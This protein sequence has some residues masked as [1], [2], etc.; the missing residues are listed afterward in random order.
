[1]WREP[2]LAI[3]QDFAGRTPGALVEVKSVALAW[4]YRMVD[5]EAGPRRANELQ[6]HL[7]QLLSNQPVESLSGKKVL[8]IRPYG[9]NKPRVQPV[10]SPER[11]PA[12]TIIA[13]RDDRPDED[14]FAALPPQAISIRV[15]PGATRARYRLDGVPAMRAL[16]RSF[17]ASI[18]AA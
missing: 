7:N 6:L 10:L 1:M 3:F 5:Q 13:A 15:G 18:V 9:I 12:I 16:L 2:L 14:L 8:E 11:P 4:H 17:T